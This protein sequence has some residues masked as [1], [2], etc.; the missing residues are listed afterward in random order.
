MNLLA[1]IQGS[2]LGATN[3]IE[4]VRH[5]NGMANDN[6]KATMAVKTDERIR[7]C[8]WKNGRKEYR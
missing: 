1:F 6:A 3:G 5:W 7:T 8:T 4:I 2:I